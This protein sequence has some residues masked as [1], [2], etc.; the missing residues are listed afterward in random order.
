MR[1]IAHF[2]TIGPSARARARRA[3]AGIAGLQPFTTAYTISLDDAG[4]MAAKAFAR[5]TLPL[6]KLKLGG[7]GDEERL[8]QVRGRMPEQRG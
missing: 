7:D 4:A 6:L 1:S 2:G 8:R 3:S 5:A